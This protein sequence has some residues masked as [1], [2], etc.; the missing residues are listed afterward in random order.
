MA[1]ASSI[2]SSPG[3]FKVGLAPWWSKPT[4]NGSRY[5]GI[6]GARGR[7]EAGRRTALRIEWKYAID[8]DISDKQAPTAIHI[9]S[10]NLQ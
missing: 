5:E 9:C 3:V 6:P 7:R 1:P 8:C 10:T 4:G 2:G